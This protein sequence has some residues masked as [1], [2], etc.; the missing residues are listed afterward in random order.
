LPDE[1][2]YDAIGVEEGERHTKR[3]I[4]EEEGGEILAVMWGHRILAHDGEVYHEV[5]SRQAGC[6]L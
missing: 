1:P 3:D 5:P 2:R 6:H 4:V